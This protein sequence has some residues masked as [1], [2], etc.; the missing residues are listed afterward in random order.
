MTPVPGEHAIGF[1]GIG[2]QGVQLIA[3]T[4]AL[5][6]AAEGYEVTMFGSYGGMMRGGNSDATV[7]I[8]TGQVLAPP[9][10]SSFSFGLAMHPAYWPNLR[11]RLVTGATALID[12]SIFTEPANFERGRVVE[13]PATGAAAAMGTPMS[14]GMLALG[15][16]VASTGLVG[17]G[18]VVEATQQVL[19][20]YRQDHA[21]ANA[22]AVWAGVEIVKRAP[23]HRH[24]TEVGA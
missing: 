5:A 9:T 3:R 23:H 4:L 22:R 2:G 12:S 7:V 1:T 13:I 24:P 17:V 21:Q 14:A 19:P 15:A 18:A 10:V 16:F 6:A 11:D 8:G 20:T